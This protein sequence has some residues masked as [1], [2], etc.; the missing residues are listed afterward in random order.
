MTSE[1]RIV[2]LARGILEHTSAVDVYLH[3]NGLPRHTENGDPDNKPPWGPIPDAAAAESRQQV[4]DACEELRGLLG[5]PV[6]P[7]IIDWTRPAILRVVIQLRLAELVPLHPLGSAAGTPFSTIA[8][9]TR[10]E[11]SES[12][13]RRII[14]HA[15]AHGIFCEPSEGLVAHN[16]TSMLL[17]REPLL[18]DLVTYGM[19]DMLPAGMRLADAL[20]RFPDGHDPKD[21][22]F[23]LANLERELM[24]LDAATK[25]TNIPSALSQ[26]KS[27]WHVHS[28]EPEMARRFHNVMTQEFISE[29]VYLEDFSGQLNIEGKKIVD[30]GGGRGSLAVQAASKIPTTMFVIQDSEQNAREGQNSLPADLQ[31]RVKFMAHDFFSPQPVKDAD[32]YFFRWIL[33][34]WSDVHAVEIIQSLIPAMRPGVRVILNELVIPRPGA[35]SDKVFKSLINYDLAMMALF[36]GQERSLLEWQELFQKADRRFRFV[37]CRT[38][39]P[40]DLSIIEFEWDSRLHATIQ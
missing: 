23:A 26:R 3:K 7:L 19:F 8:A 39:S 21:T 25:N 28:Q 27:L 31:E 37:A 33:H 34:D 22:G 29:N 10:P 40:K 2:A 9:M 11:I 5:G 38:K 14:R 32:I 20:Q 6:L 36:N 1:S 17:I 35:V 4:M 24:S 15:T 18:K 13:F 16:T 30:V 12:C